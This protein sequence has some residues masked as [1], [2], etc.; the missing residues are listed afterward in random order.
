MILSDGKIN[1]NIPNG[2]IKCLKFMKKVKICSV[3]VKMSVSI[4]VNVSAFPVWHIFR[5]C[6]G[7]EASDSDSG[8][9][10]IINKKN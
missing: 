1:K 5:I 4:S 8:V 6:R 7:C 9:N 10:A 3:Y 2:K